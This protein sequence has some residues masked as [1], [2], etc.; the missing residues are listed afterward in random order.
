M[1]IQ[2]FSRLLSTLRKAAKL[3]NSELAGRANVPK[4]LIAGLQ[5]GKRRI[6][7]LQA[8]RLGVAL[9]LTGSELEQFV[10]AAIDTCT[11][12]V[13]EEVKSYPAA[14]INLIARQ[15][16]GAGILAGS[17]L[18]YAIGGTSSSQTINFTMLNGHTARLTTHLV[19]S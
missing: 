9:G 2:P 12:K 11:E 15:L 8:R 14:F 13:L 3:T 19:C 6:G 5:S 18:Q 7:E 17:I 4:S 16:R 10:L 1:H